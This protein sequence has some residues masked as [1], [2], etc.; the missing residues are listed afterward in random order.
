MIN[1]LC[2]DLEP[3]Y[4]AELVTHSFHDIVKCEVG[5]LITE[6]VSPILTLL[7]KHKTKATFAV[8]GIVAERHPEI[9]KLIH[10]SGHEIAS[11][12]YSHKMLTSLTPGDFED[13][14]TKSIKLIEGITGNKPIGFRAPSFSIDNSNIWALKILVKHGFKYDASVFPIKTNL[15]GIPRAPLYPYK[16]SLVNIVQEDP[17]GKIVEF[18]MTALKIGINIPVTGGFYF[19]CIPL[20]MQKFGISY[21]NKKRPAFLY[22]H[23]WETYTKTPKITNMSILSKFIT[24]YG[25][26]NALNKLDRLLSTFKFAPIHEVIDSIKI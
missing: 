16:P 10:S 25:V 20:F 13:E 11:H 5:D 8:L 22:I 21:I 6:S 14:I 1:A 23:P 18:P 12:G 15:Y 7:D 17:Y 2:V 19:R 3:W 24:Y 9:I 26:N 4:V